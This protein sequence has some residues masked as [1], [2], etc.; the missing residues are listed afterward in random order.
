[1]SDILFLLPENRVI[2]GVGDLCGSLISYKCK[3]KELSCNNI[4][5]SDYPTYVTHRLREKNMSREHY[6]LTENSC[7]YLGIKKFSGY[8][9]TIKKFD[10]II[11]P[12]L[13]SYIKGAEKIQITTAGFFKYIDNYI[14]INGDMEIY[15]PK[16]EK[17][18]KK[19]IIL[20][21]RNIGKQKKLLGGN[22]D[23]DYFISIYNNLKNLLG[24]NYEFWKVGEDFL[25][26]DKN[27]ENLFDRII[28]CNYNL[29]NLFPIIRNSSMVI[30][31]HSGIIITAFLFGIPTME[32][33]IKEETHPCFNKVVWNSWGGPDSNS[34]LETY[35][36]KTY[37]GE[38]SSKNPPPSKEFLMEF[39]SRNGLI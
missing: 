39:I 3:A 15:T 17:I 34:F 14:R 10:Y 2:G 13:S 18:N 31:Q 27:L 30:S 22:M 26:E 28:P 32:V 24:N 11:Y 35:K 33:Y 20:Q 19:Y 8:N 16:S 1:M 9:E 4:Y 23:K 38:F 6:K 5:I 36:V 7:N 21:Y 37:G 12:Y 29:D 25:P